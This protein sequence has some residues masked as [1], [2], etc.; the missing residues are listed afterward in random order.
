MV[1]PVTSSPHSDPLGVWKLSIFFGC[2]KSTGGLPLRGFKDQRCSTHS[3]P[4]QVAAITSSVAP[5]TRESSRVSGS[6][7]ATGGSR[8][9]SPRNRPRGPG[10]MR[11]ASSPARARRRPSRRPAGRAR[12]LPSPSRRTPRLSVAR[13]WTYSSQRISS[14]GEMP[15]V[16]VGA[17]A[18]VA[19]RRM[20]QAATVGDAVAQVPLGQRAEADGA[21]RG[22]EAR[23]GLRGRCGCS[24]PR[25]GR[26]AV[27]RVSRSTSIGRGRSRRS[28]SSISRRC[29]STWMWKGSPRRRASS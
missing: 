1:P 5:K 9:R 20:R 4:T 8:G 16:R 23:P 28:T 3:P 25:S 14:M 11:P 13:R 15:R 24:G 2:G 6:Q 19:S 27:P 29:S 26:V 12:R 7:P 22:E 21:A 10:A 18:E 17:Q